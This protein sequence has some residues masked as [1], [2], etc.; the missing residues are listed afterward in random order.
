MNTN[1]YKPAGAIYLFPFI[2]FVLL[3]GLGILYTV[4]DQ[5]S[6]T[7]NLIIYSLAYASALFILL[8][9]Q[10][11]FFVYIITQSTPLIIMLFL[12][13]A[14]ILWTDFPHQLFMGFIHKIGSIFIAICAASI[15]IQNKNKF[16]EILLVMFF[17]YFI[18]TIIL[19]LLRPDIAQMPATLYGSYRA[20]LRGFTLHPNTLGGLCVIGVWVAMSSLFLINNQKKLISFIAAL[21]LLSIFYCLIKSD[22]M[23]SILVSMAMSLIIGWFSFIHSSYGSIR[24]LKIL[25]AILSLLV[26]VTLLFI[27]KPEVFSIDYFFKAIGRNSTLSGRTSLWEMGLKGFYAKP[28]FGWGEDNLLTFFKQYHMAFGQLHN[29]YF[30]ILVRGGVVSLFLFLILLF[31]ITVAIFQ[32]SSTNNQSY[33]FVLAFV[34]VWLVH[35]ITEAS[36]FKSPNIL[37]LVFLIGY[38]FSIGYKHEHKQQN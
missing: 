6:S 25:M 28:L 36:I 18:A 9:K 30:D 8:L 17:F 23:T 16:F 5:E 33:I 3:S 14:S 21:L 4:P 7:V 10:R 27:L 20:G 22:S 34:L 2:L 37:W 29:G 38:F 11:D 35:N 26:G 15:L 24:V 32:L 1:I 12:A 19:M 31:Q 13:L